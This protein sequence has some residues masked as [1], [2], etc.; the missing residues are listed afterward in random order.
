MWRTLP[1]QS[2]AALTADIDRIFRALQERDARFDAA[3]SW[4]LWREPMLIEEDAP[5]VGAVAAALRR[6]LGH[7]PAVC[8]APWWTDAALIRDAGIP[9]VICGPRGG[10]MHAGDEWVD[11]E[12]LARFEQV[13]LN[14]TRSFC[15]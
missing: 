9:T 13:L 10:G 3:L 7:D 5:I 1:G 12:A 14:V 15:G 8:A 2:R 6:E 4:Q 11:L